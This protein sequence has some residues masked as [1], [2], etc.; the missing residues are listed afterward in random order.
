M[1]SSQFSRYLP[2]EHGAGALL[3]VPFVLGT[4]SGTP[5]W[6]SLLLLIAWL[7]AYLT[8]YFALRWWKTRRL[9]H[10]GL[11]YR[12][13][14]IVY[15]TLFALSGAGLA[16]LQPWLVIAALA[17]VPFEAIAA[18]LSLQGRERSHC[19]S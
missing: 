17:F 19:L 7:T 14:A 15:G 10:R 2:P 4:L 9:Q 12:R 1:A 11:R 18:A 6:R 3:L 13:P 5:S 16:L 8:S